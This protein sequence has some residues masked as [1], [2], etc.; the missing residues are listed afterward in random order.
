MV[1]LVENFWN[2][3]SGFKVF[4]LLNI[5]THM[6]VIRL[7]TGRFLV[8]D[9]VPLDDDLKREFD[10]L[11]NGGE[12]VD[13]VLATHP[14]HSL[15]LPG[16][17]QAYPR[18]RFIGCPRHLRN[19]PEIPWAGEIREHLTDWA[20]EVQMR[21]PAGA[22]FVAPLPE[23]SNHFACVFVCHQPSR[24]VH[25]DDTV[26][27]YTKDVGLL[28][29]LVG[30][31]QGEFGFHPSIKG[32]GLFST[33]EAPTQFSEWFQ[34]LLN[35][36]DVD[37]ICCA[38]RDVMVGGARPLLQK[39]LD[40]IQPLLRKISARNLRHHGPGASGSDPDPD[41]E[42]DQASVT[43]CAKMNVHGNECG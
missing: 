17:H 11:T 8:I 22:E 34:S 3:R 6:S 7:S 32:P 42:L 23:L 30:V 13:A 40:D 37:A 2:I 16:F 38:H 39:A 21:I 19:L 4:G 25:V 9:A 5:G 31:K 10:E 33:P 14:F 36:W 43:E 35:D 15:A 26:N 1:Q 27:L 18:L 28:L 41:P 12:L 24:M 29:R 20:P